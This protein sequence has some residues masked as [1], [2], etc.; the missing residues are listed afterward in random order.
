MPARHGAAVACVVFVL[1][2]LLHPE[3]AGLAQAVAVAGG[4]LFIGAVTGA[5]AHRRAV[6]V[7][8]RGARHRS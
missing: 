6:A 3:L 2:M 8:L 4:A 7:N 1:A 5:L